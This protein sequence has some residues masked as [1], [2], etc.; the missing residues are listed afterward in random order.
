M[1]NRKSG[2]F[3]REGYLQRLAKRSFRQI[4]MDIM[5]SCACALI[6]LFNLYHEGVELWALTDGTASERNLILLTGIMVILCLVSVSVQ[7]RAFALKKAMIREKEMRSLSAMH[8]T[9]R[10]KK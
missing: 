6:L 7:F 3:K 9:N 1:K 2:S 4:S 10:R 5:L 8:N